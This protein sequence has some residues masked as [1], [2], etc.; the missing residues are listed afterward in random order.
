L[1]STQLE[2]QV[3]V[4]RRNLQ[5]LKTEK[6]NQLL[7]STSVLQRYQDELEKMRSQVK[8]QEEENLLRQNKKKDVSRE[9][10]QTIQAI[11]NLYG[12]CYS[13][14][15]VK[16]IFAGPRDNTQ[17]H[18]VLDVELDVISARMGDL[19]EITEEYKQ[20]M[21]LGLSGASSGAGL[22]VPP[23]A[24]STSIVPGG[25]KELPSMASLPPVGGLTSQSASKSVLSVN[26]VKKK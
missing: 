9:F 8:L 7:V 6:Q 19:I 23:T 24:T 3:D 10:T 5:A 1:I 17:L 20:E 4:L 2:Q 22:P 11:R 15:G 13:T 12:R 18:E 14:M 21:V 16:S 25:D 26:S